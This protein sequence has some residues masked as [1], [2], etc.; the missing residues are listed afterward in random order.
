MREYEK[1]HGHYRN[2]QKGELEAFF[3]GK[4]VRTVKTYY[5]GF[6][7]WSPVTRDI[8]NLM[9]GDSID[10]QKSMRGGG[11]FLSLLL[12]YSYRYF[13]SVHI[14]DQFMGLFEKA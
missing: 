9:P 3:N 8:L 14:G 1:R 13:S 4:G 11:R 10:A 6:P 2:F 7:F 12:Y 5:A